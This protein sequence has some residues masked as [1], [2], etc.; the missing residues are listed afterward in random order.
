MWW[1]AIPSGWCSNGERTLSHDS[2]HPF[3]K[4][5]L[6]HCALLAW[7]YCHFVTYGHS[8]V[9]SSYGL[10]QCV[11]RPIDFQLSGSNP[12]RWLTQTLPFASLTLDIGCRPTMCCYKMR[13]Y[14]CPLFYHI[15]H[16]FQQR[17]GSREQENRYRTSPIFYIETLTSHELTAGCTTEWPEQQRSVFCIARC[18]T[19]VL[20]CRARRDVR[21][22][23]KTFNTLSSFKTTA[24]LSFFY[25]G[26]HLHFQVPKIVLP[27]TLPSVYCIHMPVNLSSGTRCNENA[28][29]LPISF[30]LK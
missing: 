2:I 17:Y 9:E 28:I 15:L 26:I 8:A 7:L 24:T 30:L 20:H 18:F 16:I 21:I 14:S 13:S 19:T 12:W 25:S 22:K 6:R 23:L 10:S 27:F 29:G 1:E 4:F 3:T 11:C 5:C